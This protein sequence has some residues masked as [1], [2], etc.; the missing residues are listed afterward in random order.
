MG[1]IPSFLMIVFQRKQVDDEIGV[2]LVKPNDRPISQMLS[3]K[4]LLVHLPVIISEIQFISVDDLKSQTFIFVQMLEWGPIL[5]YYFTFVK[6][7]LVFS[8]TSSF[9]CYLLVEKVFNLYGL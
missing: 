8:K 1:S 5:N 7:Y 9:A 4:L 2:T 3:D 6:I